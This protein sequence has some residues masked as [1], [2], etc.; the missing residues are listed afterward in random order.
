M[1]SDSNSKRLYRRTAEWALETF[2]I[3]VTNSSSLFIRGGGDI[4][5]RIES[6]NMRRA[7]RAVTLK[8]FSSS[9]RVRLFSSSSSESSSSSTSGKFADVCVAIGSNLDVLGGEDAD[10]SSRF[11]HFHVALR[12]LQE[13][14]FEIK[15]LASV[16]ETKP[17]DT[18]I[19]NQPKFLNSACVLRHPREWSVLECLGKM[20]DIEREMGR[21]VYNTDKGPRVIDLDILFSEKEPMVRYD[22][23]PFPSSSSS[24]LSSYEKKFWLEV[25]HGRIKERAFVLAPIADLTEKMS[26][27]KS[28]DVSITMANQMTAMARLWKEEERR[29]MQ[30]PTKNFEEASEDDILLQRVAPFKRNMRLEPY[31]GRAKVMGVLNVTPD[32]FSDGGVFNTS[33]STALR[34]AEQLADEGSR[35]IDVGGQ[36]TR[37]GASRVSAADEIARV[38]P[39]LEA[40]CERFKNDQRNIAVSVDT[41]YGEVVKVADAIGVDIINDVSGGD[42]DE[43]ML[44]AVANTKV[45][46]GYVLSHQRGNPQVMSKNA[47]YPVGSVAKTV[48]DEIASQYLRKVLP[49][50]ISAWRCWIDPGFGF[51]KSEEQCVE[52]LSDLKDVRASLAKNECGG[53]AKA[54]MLVGMSRKRFVGNMLVDEKRKD[55]PKD[56]RD[57]ASVAAAIVALMNGANAVRAHDVKLHADIAK[58]ADAVAASKRKTGSYE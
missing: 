52:L 56:A 33:V 9:L 29:I 23:P 42:W 36:S 24:S 50:G 40:V 30:T 20:K 21:D 44:S 51:A 14:G 55:V 45:P 47:S 49:S 12:L 7:H 43:G 58:V 34:R 57:V 31:E 15:K 32:S 35:I 2:W 6:K 17:V 28:G 37:P 25:P 8:Y 11:Q 27:D 19:E 13:R 54:P 3:N 18:L 22:P 48:G 16:Y 53:L 39:V 41:F 46:L 26:F 38:A 5:I 10:S 4:F 1:C